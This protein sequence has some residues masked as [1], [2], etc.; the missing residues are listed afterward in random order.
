M[1]LTVL[2]IL[3]PEA[4][5]PRATWGVSR[6]RTLRRLQ[7]HSLV[8]KPAAP[9]TTARSSGTLVPSAGGIS[10]SIQHRSTTRLTC[11]HRVQTTDLN[12]LVDVDGV[13]TAMA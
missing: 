2:S 10:P 11:E 7:R 8:T 12:P 3:S 4:V 5:F 1:A 13:K 6:D 9:E